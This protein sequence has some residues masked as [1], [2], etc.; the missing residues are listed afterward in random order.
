MPPLLQKTCSECPEEFVTNK[1]NAKVCSPECRRTRRNRRRRKYPTWRPARPTFYCIVCQEKIP[2]ER[3]HLALTCTP[4]CGEEAKRRRKAWNH[5][6]KI[7]ERIANRIRKCVE[8]GLYFRPL[9]S[10]KI[11]CSP[12]C[13]VKRKRKQGRE[14]W[15]RISPHKVK[16]HMRT[17][18][19]EQ[20]QQPFKTKNP[21][22][23]TCGKVCSELRHSEKKRKLYQS[24]KSPKLA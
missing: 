9:R 5:Y 2:E 14:R 17:V 16:P 11:I 4:E 24:K 6:I 23:V 18:I 8:C 22:Q 7:N 10:D 15:K 1:P 12:E 13:K 21:R 20:C 19:C 3:H